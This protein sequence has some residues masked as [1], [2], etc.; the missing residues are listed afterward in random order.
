MMSDTPTKTPAEDSAVDCSALLVEVET[1]PKRPCRDC[2]EENWRRAYWLDCS[3]SLDCKSCGMEYEF[4]G[5]NSKEAWQKYDDGVEP[6][7]R[8]RFGRAIAD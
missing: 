4:F 5:D 7:G 6:F 8:Y 3:W 2:G 1:R